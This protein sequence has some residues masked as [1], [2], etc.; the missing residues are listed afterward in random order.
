MPSEQLPLP[1]SPSD[2][3]PTLHL[4]NRVVPMQATQVDAPFDDA[5]YFFE[6]WWPGVR[7]FALVERGR[8]RLQADGLADA[9]ATF[10]EMGELH[11]PAGRGRRRAGWHAAGA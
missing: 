2:D 10:P 5:D 9:A 4:P 3:G 1:V 8:L 7:A 6:P 11:R